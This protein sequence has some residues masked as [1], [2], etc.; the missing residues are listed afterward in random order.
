MHAYLIIFFKK[1]ALLVA[2]QQLTTNLR[3]KFIEGRFSRVLW[4]LV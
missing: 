2:R 1:Y 4:I 3:R